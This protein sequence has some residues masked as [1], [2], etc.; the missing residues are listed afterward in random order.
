MPA[1]ENALH[2]R[3]TLPHS[4]AAMH[5]RIAGMTL[6][7]IEEDTFYNGQPIPKEARCGCYVLY[8]FSRIPLLKTE[9]GWVDD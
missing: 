4:E 2:K 9:A 6:E 5:H 8:G 7:A 1:S 3:V